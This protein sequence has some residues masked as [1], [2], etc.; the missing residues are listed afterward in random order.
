MDY[1]D[2]LNRFWNVRADCEQV[3]IFE[4]ILDIKSGYDFVTVDGVIFTGQIDVVDLILDSSFIVSFISYESDEST[5]MRT[6]SLNWECYD[7]SLISGY[8]N[9]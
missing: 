8:I 5:A 4:N 2:N 3:N 7:E 9:L 1:K 6:F